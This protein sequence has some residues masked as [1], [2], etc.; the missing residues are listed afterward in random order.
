MHRA[1]AVPVALRIFSRVAGKKYTTLASRDT[2]NV[3]VHNPLQARFPALYLST[4]VCPDVTS[5]LTLQTLVPGGCAHR[6]QAPGALPPQTDLLPAAPLPYRCRTPAA[7]LPHRCR[8]AAAHLL[9]AG[10]ERL[11]A[12]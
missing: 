12:T 11:P 5:L 8:T 4:R 10:R 2:L 3:S 6:M 7:P 1:K 9:R